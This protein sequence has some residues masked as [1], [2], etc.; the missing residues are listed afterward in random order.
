MGLLQAIDSL[1]SSAFFGGCLAILAIV[2][3]AERLTTRW[4]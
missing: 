2:A 3:L 1:P 4:S